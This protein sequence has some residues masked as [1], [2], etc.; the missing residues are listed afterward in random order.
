MSDEKKAN[1]SPPA[2][3][4]RHYDVTLEH[5]VAQ[6]FQ[7]LRERMCNEFPT[8]EHGDH[9]EVHFNALFNHAVGMLLEK[10]NV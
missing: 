1:H 9:P 10:E 7:A 2:W 4:V 8:D 5:G 6:R 3:P